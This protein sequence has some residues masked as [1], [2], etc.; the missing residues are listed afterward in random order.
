MEA[1]RK[2]LEAERETQL[3][4]MRADHQDNMKRLERNLKDD[5]MIEEARVRREITQQ[6]DQVENYFLCIGKQL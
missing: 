3:D 4:E 1:E 2:C 6:H 5:H